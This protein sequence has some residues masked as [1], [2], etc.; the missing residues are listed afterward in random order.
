VP[1]APRPPIESKIASWRRELID[2]GPWLPQL[3]RLF[4][5]MFSKGGVA[6]WAV[7][8]LVTAWRVA[9]SWTPSSASFD[10]LGQMSAGQ[11]IGLYLLFLVLKALH[12]VGHAVAYR[13]MAAQEGIAVQSVH[14]G[15]SMMF[16]MPFPFTNVSGAWRLASRWRRAAVGAAGM[17]VES[18]P[19]ILAALIWTV[20]EDPVL[21][22]AAAQVAVVAGVS[23]LLF[24]LN[25]LGRMDG[26]YIFADLIDRPNLARQSSQAALTV[27]ARVTGALPANRMATVEWPLFAY[28]CGALLFRVSVYTALFWAALHFG[29]IA[30]AMLL[31]L[32]GSLLVVRP[33][34]GSLRWLIAVSEDGARTR[35]RLVAAAG[36]ALLLLAL[37]IPSAVYLDGVV[38]KT[39]LRMIY[40]PRAA[41]IVMADG[42]PSFSPTE[43]RLELQAREAARAGALTRWQQAL[44]DGTADTQAPAEGAAAAGRQVASLRRDVTELE[45]LLNGPDVEPL[46]VEDFEGAVVATGAR[47]VAVATGSNAYVIRAVAPEAERDHLTSADQGLARPLG[48]PGAQFRVRLQSIEASTIA[49]LPSA[50]LGRTGGGRF[51]VDPH[52]S[53]GRRAAEPLVSALVKPIGEAPALRH[54]DRVEIR[55]SGPLRPIAWQVAQRLLRA[56]D[57]PLLG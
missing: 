36:V 49:D 25:P 48:R 52:D 47:P 51:A 38:E 2:L 44:T 3:D 56:L 26:Y 46:T 8:A 54:G 24:N 28:W 14:A 12:E 20:V 39:G 37:P 40:P 10:W 18:W 21:R 1:T 41:R 27:L 57:A 42:R 16:L 33:L 35:R 7:L 19:A 9:D 50:A 23:T 43:A 55:M 17:Y 22:T 13:R 29:A 34:A 11:A 6:V 53:R 15:I 31:L 5:G 30:A 45:R 4:G 32:A